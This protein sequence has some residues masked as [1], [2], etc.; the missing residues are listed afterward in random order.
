M[1]PNQPAQLRVL[2]L[3]LAAHTVGWGEVKVLG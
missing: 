3:V 2:I 1:N